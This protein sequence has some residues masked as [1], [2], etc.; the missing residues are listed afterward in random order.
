MARRGNAIKMLREPRYEPQ[1][2]VETETSR[3]IA[4]CAVRQT[5]MSCAQI[6][7][8]LWAFHANVGFGVVPGVNL[9][10]GITRSKPPV[11]GFGFALGLAGGLALKPILLRLGGDARLLGKLALLLGVSSGGVALLRELSSGGVALLCELSLPG[12]PLVKPFLLMRKLNRPMTL[13]FLGFDLR[14]GKLTN[15]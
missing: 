3:G 5:S 6:S 12:L 7:A 10:G 4:K 13:D 8:R 1:F 2:T 9:R 14:E 11:L 15:T